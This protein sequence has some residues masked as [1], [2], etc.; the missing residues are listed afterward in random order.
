MQLHEWEFLIVCHDTAKFVGYPYCASKGI[1]FLV[2]HVRLRDQCVMWLYG[3]DSLKVC[4]HPQSL[5]DIDIV[6]VEI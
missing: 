1:M 5:E 2:S 4:H 3:Q 6:V